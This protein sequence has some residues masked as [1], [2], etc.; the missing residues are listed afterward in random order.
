MYLDAVNNC[1]VSELI[2]SNGNCEAVFDAWRHWQPSSISHHG[3]TCCEIAREWVSATDFA[4]LNGGSK[5]TGPRWLRQRFAWGPGTYP[6]YWCEVLKKKKLDCGV[7]A[8]LAHEVFTRRGIRSFRAQLVQEFSA[9]AVT[10]W[11]SAWT[12]DQA[13]TEW[14]RGEHIYHEGCAVALADNGLKLWDSSAGCWIDPKTTSGYGSVRA[15]RIAAKQ[16]SNGLLWGTHSIT[17]NTWI[18]LE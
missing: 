11:N 10:Q 15:V 3:R 14:M 13:V 16:T 8:A 17:T 2:P 4:L 12:G 6:I 18:E 1:G 7:H 9:D 5:L